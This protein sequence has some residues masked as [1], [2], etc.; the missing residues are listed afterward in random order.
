MPQPG[1]WLVVHSRALA[2]TEV[3][4]HKKGGECKM[5]DVDHEIFLLRQRVDRLERQIAFLLEK[6]DLEYHEEPTAGVPPEILELVRRGEKIKAVKLYRQHT[7]VGLKEAKEFID[8][9]E[10]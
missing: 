10:V 5:S 4:I 1:C 3:Y 7:F 6:N 9:L 8:S 2:Y